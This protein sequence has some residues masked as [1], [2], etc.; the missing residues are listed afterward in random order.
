MT[1]A[2][3]LDHPGPGARRPGAGTRVADGAAIAVGLAIVFLVAHDGSFGWRVARAVVVAAATAGLVLVLAR[4]PGAGRRDPVGRGLAAVVSGLVGVAVGAGIALPHLT[5]TGFTP[6]AV[7]GTVALAGGVVLVAAGG[8]WLLRGRRWWQWA[9]VAVALVVAL[10]VVVLPL[11]VAVAVTNVPRTSLDPDTPA[12]RGLDHE[13]VEM[14]T[15]DGVTL[16]GW[17][18]PGDSGA[19]VVL[20]H[21]AGSTRSGVLDQA[22][23][24]AQHGFGVLAFDARGHGESDGRAM[25]F[26]WYGDE[27]VAAAVSFLADQPGVD[28]G[29]IGAVGMS[30]G[31]EQVIGAAA[32]DD[33][34]AAVVAEGAEARV[35]GDGDW[36]TDE[37]GAGGWVQ[38]RIDRLTFG[39]TDLLTEAGPPATLHDA[40]AAA[41]PRP[42]LLIAAGDEADEGHAARHIRSASPGTVDVWVVP[43]AGH[44]GGLDTAPDEWERRVTAFLSGALGQPG[45]DRTAG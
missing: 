23:V 2:T 18:V 32:A 6:V 27:D 9:L 15:A 44:T 13:G 1:T 34:I 28:P 36:L 26:G 8:W 31:G 21:G 14:T 29:R 35:A 30:M 20:A 12:D 4:H 7:A 40:T 39:L 24:L 45:D 16:R 19:A 10:P 5:K 43:G 42:M 25:D 22:V 37:Y 33:R 3:T 38:Q 11:G 41:A 17:Y